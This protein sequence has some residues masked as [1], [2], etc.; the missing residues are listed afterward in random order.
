MLVKLDPFPK[1]RG[2]NKKYL[3]C[4]H[5]ASLWIMTLPPNT[6]IVDSRQSKKL[7]QQS[8]PQVSSYR[9]GGYIPGAAGFCPSTVSY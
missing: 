4:H 8:H 5:L 7:A 9:G 1:I 6:M 3:S 2:E